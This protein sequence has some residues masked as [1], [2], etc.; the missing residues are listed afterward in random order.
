MDGAE[1]LKFPTVSSDDIHIT[2]ASGREISSEKPN[3]M[4]QIDLKAGEPITISRGFAWIVGTAL[5]L[6][7][8]VLMIALYLISGA[9]GYQTVISR[10]S[11]AEKRL[12]KVESA[13]ADIQTLKMTAAQV[14]SDVKQ[15]KDL[16]SS[17]EVD[18][19]DM[20]KNISDIRILLATKSVSQ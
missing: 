17:N 3:L 9:M 8:I 2:D 11:D 15:I 20:Q 10:V 5:V 4:A 13:V 14:Q 12:D 1:A 19:K 7:P 18:R 6:I 16:Q